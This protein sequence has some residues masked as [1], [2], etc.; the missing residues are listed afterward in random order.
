MIP[1]KIEFIFNQDGMTRDAVRKKV[2]SKFFE[3]N[4]GPAI[5]ETYNRYIYLVEKTPQGNILLIRPANLKMGF[6]FRIDVEGMIFGKERKTPNAPKHIDLFEDLKHKYSKDKEFCSR[7][8]AAIIAV[9]LMKDPSELLKDIDDEN[10]GYSVEL[11]L[12]IS[13]WFAIEQDI[14]YW[15]GW[16]RNKQIIWLILMMHFEFKY[17]PT[18]NGFDFYDKQGKLIKEE[19]AMKIFNIKKI[20]TEDVDIISSNPPYTYINNF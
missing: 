5:D 18:D 17:I 8:V 20:F 6:D 2:V 15:N 1:K 7:V 19:K 11:L 16:G 12:K 4:P 3:E 10:I 14:R 13:K 9:N